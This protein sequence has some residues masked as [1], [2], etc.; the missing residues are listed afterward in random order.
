MAGGANELSL[1]DAQR[2]M[3]PRR[4]SGDGRWERDPEW[5][6]LDLDRDQIEVPIGGRDYGT[7]YAAD[8]TEYYYWRR[9][10]NPAAE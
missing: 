2:R 10:P 9:R 7:S 8:R 5:R 1:L 4:E 6:T 3:T